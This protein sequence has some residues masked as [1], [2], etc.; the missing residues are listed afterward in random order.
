MVTVESIAA[1][2]MTSAAA[3]ARP[4]ATSASGQARRWNAVG[5][6]STGMAAVCPSRLVSSRGG[7]R[8]RRTRGISERPRNAASLAATVVSS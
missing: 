6:M 8:P 7:G 1:I 3:A 4:V 2:M 5:A